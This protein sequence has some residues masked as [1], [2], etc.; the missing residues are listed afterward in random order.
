MIRK[1]AVAS[2]ALSA[3]TKGQRT[4]ETI[5]DAAEHAFAQHGFDG[6]P[7]RQVAELSG[8]ALGVLTYHFASKEKL[9]E[10]VVARRAK[11]INSLRQEELMK[12]FQPG[13]EDILAAFLGPF[14]D[15]MENGGSGWKAY[16][17]LLAQISHEA[18]WAALLAELFGETAR[19][20]IRALREAEPGLT[21]TNAKRGYVHVVAV[22]VGLFA[23]TRLMDQLAVTTSDQDLPEHYRSAIAF[24]SAGIRALAQ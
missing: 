14:L 21:L 13:V 2:I 9:F 22:M 5:L 10:T 4:R 23:S 20:F 24:A 3:T 12:F 17:H 11:E 8:Q 19:I 7:M 1:S 16:A 15:R 18:R 6:V